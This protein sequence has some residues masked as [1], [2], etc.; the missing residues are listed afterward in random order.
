MPNI[1]Q[2][3]A[4]T[5]LTRTFLRERHDFFLTSQHPSVRPTLR[6]LVNKYAMPA[7]MWRH[8]I[9]SFLELLRYILPDSLDHA[10]A[11]T[12]L[13]N[14]MMALMMEPVPALED[15]WIECLGDP[16]RYRVV[17]E[18]AVGYAIPAGLWR[19]GLSIE[20]IQAVE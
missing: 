10:L 19:R 2:W 11:F 12:F 5:T 18:G 9:H 17:M 15:T 14:F 16:A 3:K 13:A 20:E 7:C 6:G 4:L 8:G 1:E